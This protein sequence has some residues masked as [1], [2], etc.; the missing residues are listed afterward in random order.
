M[1]P[2][3]R[4]EVEKVAKGETGCLALFFVIFVLA[5]TAAFGKT[6]DRI[7]ALEAQVRELKGEK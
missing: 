1:T 7:T 5:V 3:D 2:E 4:A 6:V